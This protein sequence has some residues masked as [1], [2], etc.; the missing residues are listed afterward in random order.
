MQRLSITSFLFLFLIIGCQNDNT[1]NSIDNYDWAHYLG[2]QSTNQYAPL[3]QINTEN[4]SQL[5]VAWT[6]TCGDGDEKNRSQIQCN[7]L[8]INGILYGSTPSMKFFALDAT[9]GKEI[10]KF[11]PYE[12]EEFTQFG[13]G[14][15]RG[16]AHWTDGE[17]QRLL[18]SAGSFLY[19]IDAKT[20]LLI[21][22]FGK[23]G[24]VDMHKGLGR[25]VDDLF[26]TANTPGI[27][28]KDKL[29]LG[30]RV[31][32]STGAAPGHIRA[33]NVKT[34]AIDWVFHTIPQPG[35]YG[36]DTWP[37]DAWERVGGANAWSGFSLDE[38]RGMVFVP[39]GSAS[40]DFYGGDRPG[41][42]LFANSLIA[43]NATTGERIWHFQTV[44]H[45]IWDR[46]IPCPPNLLTVTHNGKKIDA[47][48]QVTKSAFVF[49]FN[50]ETGEP[51]FPVEEVPI[52]KSKLE[53]EQDWATQPVPTKPPQFSRGELTIDELSRRTPE[54]FKYAL[55][56]FNNVDKHRYFSPPSENGAI[57]F[58]GLDGGGEW[59]GGA[60]DPETAT[61]YIN[62]SE[63]AW[64][65][66]MLPFNR[67]PT[68]SLVETGHRLY[69]TNC[70][71]CHGKDLL[72]GE[73]KATIPPLVNLKDRLDEAT[74]AGTVKNGKGAMPAFAQL[75]DFQVKA[76]AAFLLEK[77]D[78][79]VPEAMMVNQRNNWPYPYVFNGYKRFQDLDGYPA[80]KPPWGTLNA[81]NLNTGEI[82]WKKTFG[83][84]PELEE[85]GITDTGSESYG[86][87]IVTKGGLIFIAASQDEMMRAYDKK[88]GEKLWETKLPAGGFATPATYAIDGKQYVVIAC[89]GGKM[90]RPSGDQYV[91]FALPN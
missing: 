50:R 77:P 33:F 63:M 26:I 28:Y 73:S 22:S 72:G 60:V 35:E 51:L 16:L 32:E 67:K 18:V 25:E 41:E 1:T 78:E 34:G 83:S 36:Y 46:D 40:F 87:P 71:I 31:S 55:S 49:L 88:T 24:K 4:V 10:W 53:G 48:A 59:G 89:G 52:P 38:E 61:L 80:I 70:Q 81:I 23:E 15:N 91:A 19:C 12:G 13:M 5:E 69:E 27:V 75:S 54:A 76:I 86:G 42:N 2:D 82:S 66:Q 43:L 62:A 29:I 20:G 74:V 6:Y 85:Q 58:P 14:V 37:K 79:K 45:D 17:E 8:V 39:T 30:A 90:G 84:F 9:S 65:L 47:V 21:K 7:P 44:H 56:I 11:N 68:Q 3:N 64:V 57:I